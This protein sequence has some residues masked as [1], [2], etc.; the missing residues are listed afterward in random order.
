MGIFQNGDYEITDEDSTGDLVIKDPNG[1]VVMRWDTSQSP[2][3]WTLNNNPIDGISSLS[4]DVITNDEE[5]NLDISELWS[6]IFTQ[7]FVH[8]QTWDSL[9][10]VG[11]QTSGSG[12]ISIG[13]NARIDLDTGTTD[14]SHARVRDELDRW[15][16]DGSVFDKDRRFAAFIR[17]DDAN[18]KL[19]IG[20]GSVSEDDFTPQHIGFKWTGGELLASVA[21]G[22]T[23][24]TTV[25]D[26]SPSTTT[27][28][29]VYAEFV[30]STEAKFWVDKN[31]NT[32]TPDA[33]LTSNLPSG[34]GNSEIVITA[35][36]ENDSATQ[37]VLRVAHCRVAQQP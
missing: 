25:L 12:T 10:R 9:D 1:N 21:D 20:T 17:N 35:H 4:S 28:L 36:V 8:Q 19:F 16:P 34:G 15:L 33:T 2:P 22:T 27:W 18:G 5:P 37:R 24:N 31:P 30:S 13:G 11:Q 23:D 6:G 32:N 26:S 29:P 7:G 14:G 3:T